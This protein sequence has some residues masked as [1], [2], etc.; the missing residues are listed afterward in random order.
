MTELA[1]LIAEQAQDALNGHRARDVFDAQAFALLPGEVMPTFSRRGP[2]RAIPHGT[3]YAY[4]RLEC[5]CA[6]CRSANA[7]WQRAYRLSLIADTA[8]ATAPQDEPLTAGQ[9]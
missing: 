4:K 5:R 2:L 7:T 8:S 9:A 1:Q 3:L 6:E